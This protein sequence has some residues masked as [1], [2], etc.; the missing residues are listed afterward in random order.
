M[1][2]TKSY[3][4]DQNIQGLTGVTVTVYTN[5]STGPQGVWGWASARQTDRL[6]RSGQELFGS[7]H[8]LPA[9][10]VGESRRVRS[11][12]DVYGSGQVGIGVY[13]PRG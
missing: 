8:D 9:R 11:G 10:Q 12:Q 3:I 6:F 5:S 4:C 2:Y 13:E 7:G 1:I